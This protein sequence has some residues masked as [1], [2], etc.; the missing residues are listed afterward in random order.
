MDE[1]EAR[2]ILGVGGQTSAEQL[3]RA[4][5]QRLRRAHPDV[6]P[7]DPG[8]A[9]TTAELVAAYALVRRTFATAAQERQADLGATPGPMTGALVVTGDSLIYPAP[10]DEVY[11]RLVA[12]ADQ[13]GEL[14]YVD[15]D[16]RV[17]DT[18]FTAADG[19]ACSLLAT[20]QGRTHGTE[21]FFT[22]EA[23]GRG[24]CPPVE[25]LVAE[26]AAVLATNGR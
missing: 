25:S 14:T 19:T 2:R 3:R 12:A 22:V 20:L 5:R 11:R 18:V 23:L 1:A 21:I 8:A 6:V 4:F 13:L 17:L 10:P 7:D 16:D 24:R 15:P 9:R 26:V